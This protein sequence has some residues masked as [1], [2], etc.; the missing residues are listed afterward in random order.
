MGIRFVL[1]TSLIA[2]AFATIGSS[3]V[4]V[5]AGPPGGYAGPGDNDE[6]MEEQQQQI[7]DE[8]DR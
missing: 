2:I 5:E 3:C 6:E 8:S 1:S 4:A 7:M